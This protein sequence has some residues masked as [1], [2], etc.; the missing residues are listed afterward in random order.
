MLDEQ[1]VGEINFNILSPSISKIFL[2]QHVVN[3]KTLMR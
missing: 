3:I 2:F 1:E